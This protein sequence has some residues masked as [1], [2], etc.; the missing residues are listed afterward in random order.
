MSSIIHQGNGSHAANAFKSL[1]HTHYACLSVCRATITCSDG[2]QTAQAIRGRRR[3]DD[4]WL[5]VLARLPV[6]G[7]GL[8][9]HFVVRR[10]SS[11]ASHRVFHRVRHRAASQGA[12]SSHHSPRCSCHGAKGS[13]PFFPKSAA[14]FS[15]LAV[16]VRPMHHRAAVNSP[17]LPMLISVL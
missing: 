13:T 1:L 7:R 2:T 3:R 10:S 6:V 4:T 5:V 8:G 15:L 9:R 16:I 17:S 11:H 12:Y 14:L